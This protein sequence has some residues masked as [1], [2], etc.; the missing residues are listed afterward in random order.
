MKRQI[1]SD[2]VAANAAADEAAPVSL[3][4]EA[5]AWLAR[6]REN[7]TD[8]EAWDALDEIARSTQRPDGVSAVY[9]EAL[10]R[11]LPAPV[12]EPL[13]KR[14][15][16]FHDEWFEDPAL[17]IRIL[18][19]A[20]ELDAR[21]DWAFERLSLLF[22]MAE[23][24]DDLLAAY[25]VA[26]AA[27]ED[28]EKKKALLD[29]AA[30]IAKDFAGSTDR[31]ISYL[32]QLVPLRPEDSQL[33]QSL[34]R[35]LLLQKRYRDLMDVWSARLP[36]LPPAEVLST[37]VRMAE[38]WLEKLAE[39]GTAL[40]VVQ[41]ILSAPNGES[42]AIKLLER[43]GT[44]AAAPLEIR[45]AAL[46]LLKERLAAADRSGDVVRAIELLLGVA[47]DPAERILLR[48]E[49]ATRLAGAGRYDDAV[50]HAAEWLVLEPTREVKATL[51]DLSQRAGKAARYGEALVRAAGATKDAV[52][53]IQ[54]LLDAGRVHQGSLDD[55]AGAIELYTRVLGDEAIDEPSL[56]DVARRLSALLVGSTHAIQRLAVLERLSVLE[57]ESAEQRRVL[58][59]AAHLARALD[60]VDHALALWQTCIDRD[61]KDQE[62]LDTSVEILEGSRRWDDLIGALRRRHDSS[63]EAGTRRADLVRI[64]EVQRAKLDNLPAAID[65]W[66]LVESEF[67]ANAET[68]N[69]LADLSAAAH[70]WSDVT[71]LLRAAAKQVEDP[72]SRAAHLARMGDVYRTQR[73][74]PLRAVEAYSEALEI[75]P[76][77]EGAREGLRAV[78]DDRDAGGLAVEAL[79]RAYA[80]AGEWQGTLGLVERR[81]HRAKE[82]EFRQNVLLEAAEILEHRAG[83]K[84]AALSYVRAAFALVRTPDIEK[85]LVRLAEET[86]GWAACAEGYAEAIASCTDTARRA[87]LLLSH[88]AILER[89]LG[90]LAGALGS[91]ARVAEAEPGELPAQVALVR[92]AGL[93][94]RWDVAAEALVRSAVAGAAIDPGVVRTFEEVTT[95]VSGWEPATR[96]V[97]EVMSRMA[98]LDPAIT[99]DLKRQLGV[100]HRDRRADLASA[101]TMLREAAAQKVDPDTLRMLADLERRAP[102]RGLTDTLLRLAAATGD[103]LE[104]L[105]EAGTVALHAVHDAELARPVLERV[106]ELGSARWTAALAADL[107]PDDALPRYVLWALEELVQIWLDAGDPKAAAEL[108]ESGSGIPFPAEK[109]R[110]LRYRAALLAATELGDTAR[111]V[112]L[113]RGILDDAPDD[114]DTIGLL[115]GLYAKDGRREE[116]LL[117]RRRELELGPAI[118]RRLVLRLDVARVIGEMGGDI[119]SRVTALEENLRDQPGHAQSVDALAEILEAEARHSDLHAQLVHQAD[120]VQALGDRIAAAALWA[121]AG[122]VAEQALKDVERA[123]DAYRRSVQ[124]EPSIGVFDA[125]AG[126]HSAR[127]EHGLAVG[128]LEKRLERTGRGADELDAHRATVL[129]LAK[130][131]KA[132]GQESEARR[133]L[134]EALAADPGATELRRFLSEL[135]RDAGEWAMLAPLLAE[136]V[137]HTPDAK[138][139]VLLLRHAAQVQRRKLGA[140][141][142]AIPLLV[143]A[144]QLTPED[145]S[146]RLALADALRGA[147]RFEEA[148]ELLDAMLVEF[149]RRRTPERAAVHYHLARIAQAEGN[150]DQALTQ[151][152]SASSIERSDPKILRL[153]GDVARQK[154]ELDAAERAYRA[155]LLIVSRQHPTPPTEDGD[156]EGVAASEVMFDLH[157]MAL[158]QGQTDRAN[159]LLESAFETA[160]SNN[161]EALR[162]ER[163]LRAAG[164]PDLVLRVLDTRLERIT[165]PA[166]AAD[167]L[168]ARADL[169]AEIGR[170]D[171]AMGSLLDALRQTPG[172]ITLL[173]SSHDL[174]VRAGAV[175]RYVARLA[176]LAELAEPTDAL[177]A[178]DLWMRLGAM[179]ENEL[180]DVSA[181]AR[182][183][184]R[185]LGTGRRALRAHRALVRVVPENEVDRIAAALRKFVESSDQD[186]TDATPR[187]EA[188]YRLAELD[189]GAPETT[190]E[191]AR[192]LEQALD[193]AP[194]YDRALSMLGS[195]VRLAPTSAALVRAYERVARA[196]GGEPLLLEAL[197]L[198]SALDAPPLALLI[199]AVELARKLSD[200]DRLG[201]LLERLVT[202]ARRDGAEQQISGALVDL[203]SIREARKDFA[204]AAE[205]LEEAASQGGPEAFALGLRVAQMAAGSL[206]DLDRAAKVYERLRR[207]E[208]ADV[209]VW[210]PLLEVYRKLR[211]FA[212][213]EACIAATVEAVYDPAER[214]HLRM[215]RGR[216]LLEDPARHGEAEGVLREVLD[217]DPDHVQA[218]VVLAELLERAGRTEELNELLDRQLG[219]AKE[220]K[221][222]DAVAALALRIGRNLEA[223]DRTAAIALYR[224]SLES[225]PDDRALLEALLR[226]YGPDDDLRDR[227]F[228]MERLLEV[229]TGEPA[230]RLA[231]ELAQVA[232]SLGDEASVERVLRRGYEIS[233]A[234]AEIKDKLLAWYTAR[235]DAQGL[236]DVIAT[237]ARHRESPH[238]AV[239]QFRE[240]ARLARDRLGDPGRALDLLVEAHAAQPNDAA[241]AEELAAAAIDASRPGEAL[242]V[243][244][245][246]IVAGVAPPDV[247]ARLLALRARLRPKVEGYEIPVLEAAIADLDQAMGLAEGGFEPA[248]ADLLEAQ[249]LLAGEQGND[250]VERAATMRLA[251]LLPKVGDQRRGLELLVGWVKRQPGDADAV[252]GLGQFAANAEKWS[253]AA[254]AYLRL[255]DIT[256]GADQID[257]VVRLAEACERAGTPMDARG[258][259]EQVYARAPGDEML[260]VRLRRMYEAAGAYGEL[261]SIMI[262]EAEQATDDQVKFGRL[263]EAG[264][265]SLRVEGGERTAIDAY[266]RATALRADDHRIVIKL[267]DTLGVVGEIEEAAQILDRAIDAFGK[268]RSPELSELQH[269]MARVGRLAGDW[270]AI[271]AWLDAAVQTDRQNGAAASELAVLAMERGELEIAIKALQAITLLKGEAPM[272][273]AEAY[274]RQGMIAEQKG[275]PKKAVFLA[276]RAMTQEPDYADAKAFLERLGAA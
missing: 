133:C 229:E 213:L 248:L 220:R 54:F 240:A 52:V 43:I 58:G 135:Y 125:L 18:S 10:A 9:L 102:G 5:V 57:P 31:A 46:S 172:S 249:R 226:L 210:K 161:T 38:T 171:E 151:L 29:E 146:L 183:Y 11:A 212:E 42:Q 111:A 99:H 233:P 89:R 270:E 62:A 168:V 145:R 231:L 82:D 219:A 236:T 218:A 104:I 22:T 225:A 17:V 153:L 33:A 120:Q 108:L 14:A 63:G 127:N 179:S 48:S 211:A 81:V 167:I 16:A 90:D 192:R 40:G 100:W 124:L 126:I 8:D 148:R 252:R 59:E 12:V 144:A 121:R 6:V 266:R 55:P 50:E 41:E 78:L 216:I 131:Y 165:D 30:R 113:C 185:S 74:A 163:V 207:E 222:G 188:L 173:S 138:E 245:E 254:K 193:R 208:P 136:G 24:W 23:R 274:L 97:S 7:P 80:A 36:V 2:T 256:E 15:V 157:S 178:S 45:R 147:G 103:D 198:S 195:A 177:L 137:D 214:N 150:L 84:P 242:G 69:A 201:V 122:R 130:A 123:L 205:L 238:E 166:A 47:S 141:E 227:A 4:G 264:D 199:D 106:L 259:L 107:E 60:D 241:L 202:A 230:L 95:S 119:A 154:G 237:D 196:V 174:A 117:L 244:S 251:H 39:A 142:V 162:F 92:V 149:G 44:F 276:K 98:P 160:A 180:T 255:I 20:L 224:E 268:K 128:W 85:E 115:A 271:F 234:S 169:L 49:A 155:L 273:K 257:A 73:D 86:D 209:R 37:R 156:E 184:E 64:A 101:E 265:L 203:A 53:R 250:A 13:G 143:R 79:A 272:S 228:V 223:T 68:M 267:A 139:K 247:R 65:T 176:E 94:G 109:I 96:A 105:H 34:E 246:M 71:A 197:T 260:R 67:G 204:G 66:R 129:R 91:Y 187:N 158:E 164:Q 116:L 51:E 72:A 87:A 175:D 77:H 194:D 21:A 70:R 261:A 26:L 112:A 28:K 75:L 35:R 25:D 118:E 3:S 235:D 132:A 206:G 232:D 200:A 93:T 262:T 170:L 1:S 258:P 19:R 189:L 32:K 239:E 140:L 269:S 186:E 182:Y 243:V 61:A 88:G 181:A 275:D 114:A 253:A 134:G 221:D 191:G 190:E 83:D 56:L 27:C 110:E 76:V 217:E 263:V 159:D 215:E 152:E